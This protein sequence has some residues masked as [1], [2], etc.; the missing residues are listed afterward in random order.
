M[1]AM[2][3]YALCYNLFYLLYNLFSLQA[4]KIE[5]LALIVYF[6]H[7]TAVL[8]VDCVNKFCCASLSEH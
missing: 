7:I 2:L 3:L 1:R 5:I 4:L 6:N 8:S